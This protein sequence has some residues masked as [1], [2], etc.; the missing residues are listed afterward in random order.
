M[1]GPPKRLYL[2]RKSLIYLI[3]DTQK[4]RNLPST[5]LLPDVY[6]S[7]GWAWQELKHLTVTC[8]VPGCAL[9]G[10]QNQEQSQNSNPATPVRDVGIPNRCLKHCT[11]FFFLFTAVKLICSFIATS[12]H[13]NTFHLP[14][15]RH[16][17]WCWR[18]CVEGP[19]DSGMV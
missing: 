18:G 17:D 12:I 9:A 15:T 11:H 5:G 4:L 19:G 13:V 6:N 14:S 16:S 8:C 2:S 10:S 1:P 3:G 7:W